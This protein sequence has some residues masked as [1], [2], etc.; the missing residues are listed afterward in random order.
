MDS[1][2]A[3]A[4]Q[5]SGSRWK[6]VALCATLAG[7]LGMVGATPA[8]ATFPGQ[9]GRIAFENTAL[10]V[11]QD[12]LTVRPDGKRRRNLTKTGTTDFDPAYSRDGRWIAFH[13][14]RRSA[15]NDIYIMRPNGTGLRR[16]ITLASSDRDPYFSP[17]G[18][19]I[20]FERE[21][22]GDTEIFSVKRNGTGLKN[23]SRSPTTT[24][25]DPAYSPTGKLIAFISDRTASPMFGATFNVLVMKP[26]G[27]GQRI[28]A[29]TFMTFE[30]DPDFSPNGKQ[31]VYASDTDGSGF[32]DELFTTTPRS[33]TGP[34][35]NLTSTPGGAADEWHPAYSPNGKRI[36]FLNGDA[37]MGGGDVFTMNRSAGGRRSVYSAGT[38]TGPNWGPKPKPRRRKR[39]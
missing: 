21:R 37:D 12:I 13:S 36:V 27:T 11:S 5:R 17:N 26:D 15:N 39:R 20:V 18:K 10:S 24:D 38:S 4:A 3:V 33:S 31:I 1:R 14:D 25:L 2:S 35:T 28:V 16:V 32:P 23:L 6:P 19:R 22:G 9:N 8:P 30:Y 7:L 34:G 29:G